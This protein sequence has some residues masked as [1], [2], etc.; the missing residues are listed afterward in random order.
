MITT[1]NSVRNNLD[2]SLGNRILLSAQTNHNIAE[3]GM[4]IQHAAQI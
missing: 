2:L 1:G 4:A 3:A